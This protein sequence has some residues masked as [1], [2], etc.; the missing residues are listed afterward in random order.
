M[1]KLDKAY[2]LESTLRALT[3]T[4]DPL[5]DPLYDCK[6]RAIL[7]LAGVAL[8]SEYDGNG[9]IRVVDA[10][11]AKVPY[12]RNP[13]V[14]VTW[15]GV[16]SGLATVKDARGVPTVQVASQG[17]VTH[18]NLDPRIEIADLSRRKALAREAIRKA[19]CRLSAHAKRRIRR[20]LASGQVALARPASATLVVPDR[21]PAL[22][23]LGRIV[24][25]VAVRAARDARTASVASTYAAHNVEAPRPAVSRQPKTIF[26][27][28]GEFV[29]PLRQDAKV[30][31]PAKV[32]RL[33]DR[34]P[35]TECGTG[36]RHPSRLC[37][38]CL[39]GE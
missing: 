38:E 7:D 6:V 1:S 10:P 2:R 24:A 21:W 37:G 4:L 8:P 28:D 33:A 31:H 18:G 34:V 25:S 23:V 27:V 26:R 13:T 14:R 20:A 35:C 22:A 36:T 30:G 15:R 9:A 5:A 32:G 3:G 16:P 29:G 19:W 39:K 12:R 11:D 17:E